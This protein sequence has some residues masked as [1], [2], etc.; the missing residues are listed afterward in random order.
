M[1]VLILVEELMLTLKFVQATALI[2]ILAVTLELILVLQSVPV[3]TQ[4]G[5]ATLSCNLYRY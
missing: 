2:L 5:S 3:V 1:W 4:S